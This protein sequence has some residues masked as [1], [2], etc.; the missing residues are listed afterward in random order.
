[1]CC[2]MNVIDRGCPDMSAVVLLKGM[3][4]LASICMPACGSGVEWTQ[5]GAI[6]MR[7]R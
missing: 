3:T 2:G 4:Y 6:K 5:E 7:L 1:M